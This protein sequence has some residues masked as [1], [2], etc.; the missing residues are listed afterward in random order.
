MGGGIWKGL[1][2]IATCMICSLIN[3]LLFL[4][5]SNFL[6]KFQFDIFLPLGG[7]NLESYVPL[8]SNKH[9]LHFY[10][11]CLFRNIFVILC[12]RRNL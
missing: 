3:Y 4:M 5:V 7:Q 8:Y 2:R 6:F 11:L 10:I 1:C 9:V 12:Q